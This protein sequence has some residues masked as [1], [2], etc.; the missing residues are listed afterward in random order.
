MSIIVPKAHTEQCVVVLEEHIPLCWMIIAFNHTVEECVVISPR[1]NLFAI[2]VLILGN[3]VDLNI[4]KCI[5]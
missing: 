3:S 2:S 4:V 5:K 1:R